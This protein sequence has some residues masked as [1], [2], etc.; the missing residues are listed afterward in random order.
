[1]EKETKVAVMD[2]PKKETK[3]KEV[4][5]KK[6]EKVISSLFK[7]AENQSAYLKSGIMGFAGSGKSFTAM[8]IAIGLH[9]FTRNK[10]PVYYLDSETG[11]DFLIP[12]F[13]DRKIELCVRKSRAFVDLV[14]SVDEAEKNGSILIIDSVSHHWTD[15][16]T[17]YCKK[18]NKTQLTLRDWV[19]L[20]QEWRVFTDK[21]V[22]SKCHIIMC[23]R[24]GWEFDYKEDE[25]GIKELTKTGTKMKVES[26]MGY[27]PSLLIEMERVR[28]QN[29][30]VGGDFIHR[31]WILKDR[32]DRINGQFFDDP[33]FEA[34]TPHVEL[35]NL[36]GE[37][38]GVEVKDSQELFDSSKSAS[39]YHKKRE[40]CLEEIQSEMVLKFG[41]TDE[42]K[43]GKINALRDIFKTSSW[44]A[45]EDMK[46][47]VLAEGLEKIKKLKG[48]E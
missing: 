18:K 32:F 19:P 1:M 16:S 8:K 5:V 14:A 37:H 30:K 17:S 28:K 9:E 33:G 11:S 6:E 42:S 39:E 29:G 13:D 35:L 45:I 22:N 26:D 24:A 12:R 10:K 25:D 3:V 34:F 36:G 15:L 20:K 44:S 43:K 38:K 23:G 27:E 47:D 31:A 46:L 21:Y 4:A 48:M 40:I 41:R 7:K 2:K